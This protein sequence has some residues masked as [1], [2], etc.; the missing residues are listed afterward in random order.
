M[1]IDEHA[2]LVTSL[3]EEILTIAALVYDWWSIFVRLAEPDK[4]T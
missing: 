2:V 1:R 4:H 3:E